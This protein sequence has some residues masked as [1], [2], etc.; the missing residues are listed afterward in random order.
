MKVKILR[1]VTDHSSWWKKKKY[2]SESSKELNFF[3]KLGWKLK[4]KEKVF[5]TS[6]VIET[7]SFHEYYLFKK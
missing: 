2:R 6:E 5:Y 3:R 1:L 4:K 7:R